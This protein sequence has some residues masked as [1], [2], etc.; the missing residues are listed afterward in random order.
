MMA[1]EDLLF[2]NICENVI[3]GDD[4]WQAFAD[5]TNKKHEA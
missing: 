3:G 5:A 2:I 1:H 4:T